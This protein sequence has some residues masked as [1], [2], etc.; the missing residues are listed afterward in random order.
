MKKSLL[1]Q[2]L[3]LHTVGGRKR[4][5]SL[6][7]IAI[8]LLSLLPLAQV[9]AASGDLDVTFGNGGIVFT[10]TTG[11]P[12]VQTDLDGAQA[13]AIQSDGKIV[14]AGYARDAAG[15]RQYT[16]VRYDANG[17][18]DP[19]FG[20]GGIARVSV[21]GYAYSVAI[22]PDGKIV[23]AGYSGTAYSVFTAVRFT[24]DGQL[25]P[26]FANNGIATVDF[27]NNGALAWTVAVQSD[28]KIVLAGEKYGPGYQSALARLNENGSLDTSF[29]TGGKKTVAVAKSGGESIRALA[30]QGDGKIVTGGWG[31]SDFALMRFLPNGQ[32][33]TTFGSSGKMLTDFLSN[34]SDQCFD[35]AIDSLGR[36]I[37]AGRVTKSVS[38]S[39]SNQYFAVARYST[40]GT[41]DTSFGTNGKTTTS[42]GGGTNLA[43]AVALQ[44]DNKIVLA[45]QV[46][47]SP[48][49]FGVAR[50][51][52]NGIIDTTFG[53]DGKVITD[54]AGGSDIADGAAIQQVYEG[55]QLVERLIVAGASAANG[56]YNFAVARYLL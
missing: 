5:T 30:I 33:D 15:V 16:V 2:N 7:T 43:K 46:G 24:T 48:M 18:L 34:S 25:D 28:L 6:F 1:R 8:L 20:N 29:G 53:I 37:A 4:L 9:H 52:E 54:L 38:K 39:S 56:G 14:A 40:N 45:G 21:D 51:Q 12:G 55:T 32:L 13:T 22:Q 17:T 35:V 31:N 10:D 47:V 49:D 50:Y 44:A 26:A 36:I 41:L 27:G 19:Y 3:R 11:V 42:F 23:V